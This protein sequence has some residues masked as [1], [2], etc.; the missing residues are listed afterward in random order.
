MS[1]N[2]LSE[3][4]N[5]AIEVSRNDFDDNYDEWRFGPKNPAKTN[6]FSL[7]DSAV[8]YLLGSLNL[9]DKPRTKSTVSTAAAHISP[10]VSELEWLYQHLGDD[11]SRKLLVQVELYRALGERFV[12]L[13]LNNSDY[14]NKLEAAIKLSIGTETLDLG[15]LGWKA[16]KL[17]LESLGYPLNIYLRPPGVVTQL[18]LQQYRCQLPDQVIE[19]IEGDT[20]IDGGGCYGET[21]LYFALK[22]GGTGQVITF[23]FMPENLTIFHQ[24]MS[25]NHDLAQRVKLIERPL[26]EHSGENLYI[27]GNGPGAKVLNDTAD[28]KARQIETISIDDVMLANKI[29]KL[30]FIKMDIEGAE[31]K[32]LMGAEKSIRKHRPK[33]AISIYHKQEDFWTIPQYIEGLGLGYRFAL[34]HFTIHQEETVLFAF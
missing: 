16:F 1:N 19:V 9:L 26:W 29:D 4:L 23:E 6:E 14:W 8:R 12:K 31:L 30:D 18:M 11:E 21:A 25:L 34:R 10:F 20:V 5:S 13:P 7:K 32:A 27:D 15:F 24:N 28:P 33:M 17:P 22:A 3:Y 2:F